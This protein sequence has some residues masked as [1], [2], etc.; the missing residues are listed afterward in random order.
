M[1]YSNFKKNSLNGLK[2]FY[3]ILVPT[4]PKQ[5]FFLVKKH[6]CVSWE[7]LKGLGLTTEAELHN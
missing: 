5:D 4:T 6:K 1:I 3:I 2:A 7:A